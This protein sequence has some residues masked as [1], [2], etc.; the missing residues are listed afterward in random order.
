MIIYVVSIF[1]ILVFILMLLVTF[2]DYLP[3]W[4]CDHI[5]WHLTPTMQGFDGCSL[6][7]TCPRCGKSVLQDSQGNWF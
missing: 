4:F 1:S 3:R 6:T 7:G 5:D 2:N